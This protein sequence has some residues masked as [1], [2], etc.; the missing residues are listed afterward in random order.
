MRKKFKFIRLYLFAT[1]DEFDEHFLIYSY[2][3]EET[4]FN[5]SSPSFKLQMF[6]S[7]IN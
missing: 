5:F 3:K 1:Y 6:P 7:S 4:A 2:D